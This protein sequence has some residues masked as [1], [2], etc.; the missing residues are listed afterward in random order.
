MNITAILAS[1][2]RRERTI[3]ALKALQA[4]VMTGVTLSVVLADDRSSD[5]TPEAVKE[6]FP[7]VEIIETPGDLYWAASMRLAEESA[8]AARPDAVLWLNDDVVLDEDALTRLVACHEQVPHAVVGGAMR[9][10]VSNGV[11]YTGYVLPG[12][13]PLKLLPV[14]PA[15]VWQRVDAL[16][17]NLVLI[18]RSAMERIGHIDGEFAHAYG[19]FDYCAR[20]LAA[21][22]PVVLAAGTF[23]TCARNAPGTKP[24]TRREALRQMHHPKSLPPASQI[25]YLSRHGG[26]MWPLYV[27]TPYVRL[28]L[29][30]DYLK[31]QT[32]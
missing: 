22:L 24:G 13:H 23:G 12:R 29:T 1:F 6:Q 19:D 32:S 30:G 15:H 28:L 17:G 11:T 18:P 14:T 31:R 16:N 7:D 21:G 9:D 4:Q 5:G 3:G 20:A 25:R 27:A 26:L 8:W 10:P 2:N